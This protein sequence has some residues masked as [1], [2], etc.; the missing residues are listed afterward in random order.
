[1]LIYQDAGWSHS[2]YRT[3]W[4]PIIWK[5]SAPLTHM[6]AKPPVCPGLAVKGNSKKAAEK[7]L[8]YYLN[9]ILWKINFNNFITSA[10]S[11]ECMNCKLPTLQP[12]KQQKELR[13][14][15][16]SLFCSCSAFPSWAQNLFTSSNEKH[17]LESWKLHVFHARDP[18]MKNGCGKL[19]QTASQPL[20]LICS[21]MWHNTANCTLKNKSALPARWCQHL[22]CPALL[23]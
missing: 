7:F 22:S 20:F 18:N 21:I 10:R 23:F 1:M 19:L 8:L 12:Q 4:Y 11:Y 13:S 15:M 16:T 2:L 17:A 6:H 9:H 14:F 5:Y 3:R